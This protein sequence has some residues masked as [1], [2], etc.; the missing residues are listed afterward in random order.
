MSARGYNKIIE[1]GNLTADPEFKSTSNGTPFTTFRLAV[2]RAYGNNGHTQ[3]DTQFFRVVVW[4]KQAEAANQYLTKGNKVLVDGRLEIRSYKDPATKEDR[5]IT[6]IV[7][8]ELVFLGGGRGEP[9][10][11]EPGSSVQGDEAPRDDEVPLF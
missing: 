5:Q 3:E 6:E 11:G 4:G 8:N 1:V 2:T 10:L 9:R 7:C